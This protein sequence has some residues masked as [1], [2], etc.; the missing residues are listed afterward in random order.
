[1]KYTFLQ[2]DPAWRRLPDARA[3]RAQA[4]VHRRLRGLRRPSACCGRSRTVGH[5]R[6]LGPDAAHPGDEPRAHPRVPRRAGPE[7]ADEV[8]HAALLVPRHDQAVGVLRRVPARSSTRTRPSTSSSIRSSRR[9]SGT[10]CRPTSAGRSCRS[11]SRSASEYPDIDLNTS[12]SFG[13]DDQEFVVAFEGDDPARFLDLVQRLRTTEASRYTKRDTPTFT[14]VAASVER[15]LERARRHIARRDRRRLGCPRCS[16][17]L[18]AC[19]LRARPRARRLRRRRRR[20]RRR[21]PR[22]PSRRSRAGCRSRSAPRRTRRSPTS[23]RPTGKSL[24]ELADAHRR[25]PRD[26]PR[27]LGLPRGRG[28][29]ARVRRD[30]RHRRLRLRQDGAV[31]S[32]RRR[33][34]RRRAPSRPPPTCS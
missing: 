22:T 20:R 27:R 30:R 11:T 26:G 10:R 1:M 14:C 25:R 34:R 33:P 29:P 5:A 28:Q 4:R 18:A 8:V 24:Q 31:L 2:V 6:R 12:Y 3:R 19:L 23:R 13:L 32:R 16:A 17:P 21:P 15:A 9:A 7:R